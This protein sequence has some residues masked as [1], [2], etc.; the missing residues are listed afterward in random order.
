M[1]RAVGSSG[2]FGWKLTRIPIYSW[3]RNICDAAS[4]VYILCSGRFDG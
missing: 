3:T 2:D 4:V 1:L